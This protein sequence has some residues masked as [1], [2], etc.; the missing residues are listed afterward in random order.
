MYWQMLMQGLATAGQI[1]PMSA[2]HFMCRQH[3]LKFR[4][5]RAVPYAANPYPC[6]LRG[7]ISTRS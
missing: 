5:G 1:D 3:V 6:R 4:F 2:W 7:V